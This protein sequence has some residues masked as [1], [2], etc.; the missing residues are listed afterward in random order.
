MAYHRGGVFFQ[1]LHEERDRLE[2][3]IADQL[4]RVY[5][6]KRHTRY[7]FRSELVDLEAVNCGHEAHQPRNSSMNKRV[8]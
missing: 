2:S 4:L 1:L 8:F 5:Q 6:C 7:D 3:L